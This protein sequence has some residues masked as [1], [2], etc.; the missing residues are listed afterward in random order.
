MIKPY[1]TNPWEDAIPVPIEELAACHAGL[2]QPCGSSSGTF[3]L[4]QE[5]VLEHWQSAGDKLDAY[6]LPCTSGYHCI[7]IRYGAEGHEYLSPAGDKDK[8]QELLNKHMRIKIITK[9]QA[10]LNKCV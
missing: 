6:I 1:W 7:G 10:I 3:I 5:K 9:V 2:N 8:V 4:T